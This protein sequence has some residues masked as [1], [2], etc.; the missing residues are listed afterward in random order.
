MDM[1]TNMMSSYGVGPAMGPAGLT[2]AIG[3]ELLGQS[4][5][6]AREMGD[7]MVQMLERSVRPELG[8]TIDLYV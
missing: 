5:D 3:T 6:L 1:N 4:L 8:G 2:Y 7:S